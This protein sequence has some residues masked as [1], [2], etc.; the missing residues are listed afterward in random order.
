MG[1]LGDRYGRTFALGCLS[2]FKQAGYLVPHH[3]GGGL[4]VSGRRA[5]FAV[6]AVGSGL[7]MSDYLGAIHSGN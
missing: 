6:G 2:T 3:P 1:P 5:L 4:S 7:A